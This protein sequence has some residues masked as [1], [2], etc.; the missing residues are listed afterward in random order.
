M[1]REE[2]LTMESGRTMD[3]LVAEK[4]FGKVKDSWHYKLTLPNY[5]TDIAAAWGVVEKIIAIPRTEE[6]ARRMANTKFGYWFDKAYLWSMT[7]GKAATEICRLALLA[8]MDD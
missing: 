8:V 6:E 2:I 7:A 3:A 1:T 4:I 5:S